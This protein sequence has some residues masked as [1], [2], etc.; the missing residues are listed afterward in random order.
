M[1]SDTSVLECVGI[2]KKFGEL[3]AV[4]GVSLEIA[5]KEIVGL[6]GPNG[7][8]KTTLINVITGFLKPDSGKVTFMHEDITGLEPHKIYRKGISRTFQIPQPFENMTVTEN[9]LTAA[10]FSG[11]FDI[12]EAKRRVYEL[13]EFV[14]LSDKKGELAGRLT[15]FER[16][17]LE[18][19]RAM[20]SKPIVLLMDEAMAGLNPTE[21]NEYTKLIKELYKEYELTM[22][23]IE[24]NLRALLPIV[25][26]VICMDAGRIIADGKP[27][28]VI[29]NEKVI[30]AYL[31]EEY[32]T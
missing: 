26:R 22:V 27:E 31:G 29:R 30:K 12:S 25:E 19:A 2:T 8:G 6:I 16:R 1:S 7:A 11:K 13:L 15:L 3:R 28:D 9:L 20:V 10:I 14:D 17:K 18:V 21:C 24:H 32:A 4:D 23:L 5:E